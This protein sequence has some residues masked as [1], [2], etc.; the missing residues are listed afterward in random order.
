M[1]R[2]KPNVLHH[3]RS[4]VQVPIMLVTF[5]GMWLAATLGFTEQ[6]FRFLG[7]GMQS[8]RLK[9]KAFRG[10]RLQKVSLFER[11]RNIDTRSVASAD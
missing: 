1:T 4:L 8:P 9:A 5:S 3:L 7:R 6:T 11:V 2:R 10:Y